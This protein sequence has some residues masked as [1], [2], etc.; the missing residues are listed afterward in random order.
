MNIKGVEMNIHDFQ[1]TLVV[2]VVDNNYWYKFSKKFPF[3]LGLSIPPR[4]L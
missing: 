3:Q 2:F 1:V 4:V